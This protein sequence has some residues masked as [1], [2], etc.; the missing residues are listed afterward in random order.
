MRAMCIVQ[1]AAAGLIALTSGVS[2]G[3]AAIM[4]PWCWDGTANASA[5][6]ECAYK[7]YQQCMA[8]KPGAGDCLANPA[9][10]PLPRAHQNFSPNTGTHH[11]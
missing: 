1:W 10:D 6:L 4:Q 8:N 11:S 5:M 7:S 2:S 9:I 3:E